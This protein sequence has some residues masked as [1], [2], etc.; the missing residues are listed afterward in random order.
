MVRWLSFGGITTI[1]NELGPGIEPH[2]ARITVHRKGGERRKVDNCVVDS[3][4]ICTG[5]KTRN[6]VHMEFFF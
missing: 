2:F 5:Q 6:V 4:I 1:T 3:R